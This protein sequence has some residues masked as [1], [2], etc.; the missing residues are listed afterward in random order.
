MI[1]VFQVSD[2]IQFSAEQIW[3]YNDNSFYGFG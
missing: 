1:E 2:A 3:V